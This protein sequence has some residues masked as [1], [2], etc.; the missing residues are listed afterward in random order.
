MSP[1][2]RWPPGAGKAVEWVVC[3]RR[4]HLPAPGFHPSVTPVVLGPVQLYNN[5]SVLLK[6][7]NLWWFLW[8]QKKTNTTSIKCS[9][10]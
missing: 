1:G 8:Q 7:L 2:R 4:E 10:Y 3:S 6:L 5:K 9:V